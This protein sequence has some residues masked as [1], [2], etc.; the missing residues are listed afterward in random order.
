MSKKL[1]K[2]Q[3]EDRAIDAIIAGMMRGFTSED[4]KRVYKQVDKLERQR[5]EGKEHQQK[6]GNDIY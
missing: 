3:R 6:T 5:R 2:K 4:W 1:S